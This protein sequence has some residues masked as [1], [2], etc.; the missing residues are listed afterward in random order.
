LPV[1]HAHSAFASYR[2]IPSGSPVHSKRQINAVK[3]KLEQLVL[4][5]HRSGLRYSEAVREFQR[6]F[7]ATALREQNANQ[8]KAAQRLRMH[9][10]TLRRQLRLLELDIDELRAAYRRP[11]LSERAVVG[12]RK[13]IA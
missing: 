8:V 3:E 2:I 4:Q 7:L 9:R 12:Q 13:Q 6:S 1:S 5:M 11:R 10:N